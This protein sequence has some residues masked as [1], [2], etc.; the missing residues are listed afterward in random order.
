MSVDRALLVVNPIRGGQVGQQLDRMETVLREGGVC[1]DVRLTEHKGHALEI[2]S[3][4]MSEGYGT[5]V[6]VGGDGTVNEVVNAVVGSKVAVAALPLGG[7][8]DFLR[9][10]GIWTWEEAC[11]GLVGGTTRDIDLGLADYRDE[12]GDQRQRYYAALADVGLGTE[13][14]HN[15]PQRFKHALGGG[16]GYVV[17]LYRTAVRGQARAYRMKVIVDGELR[18]DERLLV[19]EALNGMYAGGGLKVAPK[20]KVNDALL[21]VFMVRDMPWPMI[22]T[23]FPKIYR[24]THIEHERGEYFQV[25]E[26]AVEAEEAL[27]ISVDGEVVG[28]TP[29]IFSLI[30][31]GLKVRCL[32]SA[33][34]AL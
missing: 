3:R 16:L 21:D 10:L 6:A 4:G 14:A 7:G 17:S 23:L 2:A 33:R 26:V 20:A 34:D 24:G 13:V 11:R 28:Y 31:G 8:N 19:V 18:W 22:W 27:R 25:R 9:N 5:I 32:C 30:P 12:A 29:A 1:C 15:T